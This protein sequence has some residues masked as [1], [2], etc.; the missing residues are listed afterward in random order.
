MTSNTSPKFFIVSKN[1]GKRSAI[2]G[3]IVH[4]QGSGDRPATAEEQKQVHALVLPSASLSLAA[5]IR[6]GVYPYSTPVRIWDTRA[7][8]RA[9]AS[10]FN[11][12]Q[13]HFD[14]QVVQMGKEQCDLSRKPVG[15]QITFTCEG[16]E[17]Y[18]TE[19]NPEQEQPLAAAVLEHDGYAERLYF[20]TRAKA[21]TV[22]AKIRAD[23]PSMGYTLRTLYA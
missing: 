1:P 21:R 20:T 6:D 9:H 19:W 15:Y 8:A 3:I 5:A 23:Y 18:A 13:G 4:E 2:V 16:N 22:L 7:K 12:M 10:T 17:V 14:W 11:Q